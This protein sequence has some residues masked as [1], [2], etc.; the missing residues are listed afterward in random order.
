MRIS[1]PRTTKA[2]MISSL[3]N[4]N[5]SMPDRG[6]EMSH[7]LQSKACHIYASL[8]ACSMEH[9]HA[10]TRRSCCCMSAQKKQQGSPQ[11]CLC[12]RRRVLLG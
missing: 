6:H 11:G 2:V 4:V 10:A 8:T 9:Q 7:N 5:T 1:S 3:A 12:E